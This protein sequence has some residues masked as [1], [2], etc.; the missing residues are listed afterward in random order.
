MAGGC[1]VAALAALAAII[2][3]SLPPSN[4][5]VLHLHPTRNLTLTPTTLPPCPIS[6]TPTA[7]VDIM[8]LGSQCDQKRA[9]D[10]GRICA[11]RR[12]VKVAAL[13]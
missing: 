6:S 8:G 13:P 4:L 3:P 11:L 10:L 12:K 1:R 2:L 7:S 5:H 9:Q